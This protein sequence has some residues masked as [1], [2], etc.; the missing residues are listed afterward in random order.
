MV[1]FDVVSLFTKVTVD[2]A[3]RVAH[4]R[5]TAD[6]SLQLSPREPTFIPEPDTY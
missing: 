5:L 1:S 3:T 4:Q 2:L 6:P